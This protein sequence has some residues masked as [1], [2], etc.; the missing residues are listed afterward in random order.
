MSHEV[1]R[2]QTRPMLQPRPTYPALLGA[3][4]A[5]TACALVAAAAFVAQQ[6][7]AHGAPGDAH[8]RQTML[9][10]PLVGVNDTCIEQAPGAANPAQEGP[11]SLALACGG[12][13][14]S[15]APLIESTLGQLLPAG[16]PHEKPAPFTLGYTLAVPLLTL[17]ERGPLG[18]EIDRERVERVT[19]TL[20]L[21]K[22]PAVLYLFSTHFA[23]ATPLEP[24]LA[25]EPDNLAQTR[26]GPLATGTYYGAPLYNWSVARTDNPLTARREEALQAV[27][28]AVCQLP[29]EARA[30]VQAITVLGETHQLFP[31]FEAGMGFAG[32]YRI[33]DYSAQS[34]QNF[35]AYLQQEF[36]TVALLNR[37]LGSGYAAFDDIAPPS[38]DIR[39]EPLTRYTEHIDAFAHGMLPIAGWAYVP[40]SAPGRAAT[41]TTRSTAPWVHVYRNGVFMGKTRADRGRQDVASAL[42]QL[43][44]ANTG[45]RWDMDFRQMA[46]GLHR[47]DVFLEQ[48][49][50]E[51]TSLGSRQI[52]IMDARQQTPVL[53][54]QQTLP[55][56]VPMRPGVRAHLDQPAE[57]S[58]Y[59]FNP[60]VPYWHAFR[61]QQVAAYLEHFS[62]Q[63]GRSC[64]AEVPRYT[65]Q[66]VP[67]SN[68]GWDSNK[69]AIDQS[70]H[71]R[72]SLKLGVSLY[73]DAAY[74]ARFA[75]W[76]RSTGHHTYGITE[77]H[78]L[79]AMNQR[80]LR[81][82]LDTHAA[83][84]AQFLS[85]FLEPRW[86]GA[87]V[88][89]AAHNPFSLD[90]DNPE[91]GSDVLYR[92]MQQ[93]LRQH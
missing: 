78:P 84:G 1:Y 50:G 81:T 28:H 49:A 46:P 24:E 17:F 12:A 29:R 22:R 18:W 77:F 74:G 44:Q 89:R 40:P 45:W 20:S 60:L 61:N 47:I 92:S 83:D 43:Q 76:L 57:Q 70:L 32:P 9:L 39:T 53:Q 30:R 64:L 88:P 87:L 37:T 51:L 69:F 33:T 55:A 48:R 68:P 79:R 41:G 7:V 35:R 8:R 85:F 65:H 36:G 73:G 13:Q 19:R 82:V 16:A 10:A 56:S 91:F 11:E 90:P 23:A 21:S 62:Q 25:K 34:E 14:G 31:D 42:P 58:S 93:I 5:L 67:F 38:R 80:Q 59:Y 26:D 27:L 63:I 52:A 66:I 86:Q 6:L 15:A 72:G 4:Y 2:W 75:A 54:P 71:K 3:C